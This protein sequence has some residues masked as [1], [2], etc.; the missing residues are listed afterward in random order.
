MFAW[1]SRPEDEI[2]AKQIAEKIERRLP[3]SVAKSRKNKLNIERLGDIFESILGEAK[4]YSLTAKPNFFR[5]ANIANTFKWELKN[6][7]Y[8][9]EFITELT[10]A[11]VIYMAKK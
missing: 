5:K 4:N 8:P 11:L 6:Y 10:K 7:N 3:P 2:F 1:F 9:D